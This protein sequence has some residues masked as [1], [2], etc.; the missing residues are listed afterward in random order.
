MF[1]NIIH[2]LKE[3]D[4]IACA[5]F[6]SLNMEVW[7][8][9]FSLNEV[10]TLRSTSCT[11]LYATANGRGK[12]IASLFFLFYIKA[13]LIATCLSQIP[14]IPKFLSI[15]KKIIKNIFELSLIIQINLLYLPCEKVNLCENILYI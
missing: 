6:P 9:P 15:Y 10:W 2:F 5:F 8:L 13:Q 14:I 1:A 11:N 12:P 7:R 3:K 4:T